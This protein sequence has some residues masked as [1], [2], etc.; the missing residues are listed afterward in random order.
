MKIARIMFIVSMAAIMLLSGCN[1]P[2]GTATQTPS[3]TAS[4]TVSTTPTTK[5]TE[6]TDPRPTVENDTQTLVQ[7]A[8][9]WDYTQMWWPEGYT[10]SLKE[11]YAATG[12]Y[13]LALNAVTGYISRFGVIDAPDRSNYMNID[14]AVI[15]N[16]PAFTMRYGLA[17]DDVSLKMNYVTPSEPDVSLRMLESGTFLQRMDVMYLKSKEDEDIYGRMEVTVLPEYFAVNYEIFPDGKRINDATLSVSLSVESIY[18]DVTISEDGKTAV[19]RS[20][21]GSG[22]SIVIPKDVDATMVL[23]NKNIIVSCPIKKL[24]RDRFTGFGFIIIPSENASLSEAEH[25]RKRDS[26]TVNA[27]QISPKSR[28]QKVTYDADHG[29]YSIDVSKAFDL[30]EGELTDKDLDTYEKVRFTIENPTDSTIRV[31]LQFVK[32]FPLS[33][34]GPSP[35]LLDPETGEPTGHTIQITRNWHGYDSNTPSDSP[36]RY[37]E[38]LWYHC[39]TIIEVPA[40]SSVTYDFCVSYA[41][42]GGIE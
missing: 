7:Q 35:M 15:K 8:Y 10:G 39:Y 42:W 20:D 22:Y 37:W 34:T 40:N 17:Y 12:K 27:T 25:F 16:L 11:I 38:G 14:N 19:L 5:P 28:E 26:V 30:A 9:P 18:K 3:D 36:R 4:A 23:D 41:R 21:N 2:T 24:S 6:S 31:P 33:V 32:D 29:M 1:T 13:G